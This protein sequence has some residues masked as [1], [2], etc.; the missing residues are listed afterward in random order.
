MRPQLPQ[1]PRQVLLHF[2]QCRVLLGVALQHAWIA[3]PL[4]HAHQPFED[5]ALREQFL[6]ARCGRA[7]GDDAFVGRAELAHLHAG[8]HQRRN[9]RQ[10]NDGERQQHQRTQ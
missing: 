8:S 1:L 2:A 9:Q 3:E 10:R 4:V 5:G 6:R 7:L